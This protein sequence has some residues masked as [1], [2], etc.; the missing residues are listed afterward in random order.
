MALPHPLVTTDD[1]GM[2]HEDA[3]RKYELEES[4]QGSDLFTAPGED[5]QR[6]DARDQAEASGWIPQTEPDAWPTAL[7]RAK[8]HRL[9][10]RDAMSNLELVIGR[11]AGKNEWQREVELAV[12]E[13][14]VAFGDHV[15]EV[16]GNDGLLAQIADE[17]PRLATEIA[18]L[19]TEHDALRRD[20]AQTSTTVKGS[21]D[22][23][24]VE[25]AR[26]DAMALLERLM[27]HRQQGADLVYEAYNVDIA[28]GD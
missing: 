1:R 26:R 23:V 11:P 20:L 3:L 18:R 17:A 27:V 9:T 6:E 24:G 5:L 7:S 8:K 28:T 22:S 10:L 15:D 13:L 2:N 12:E 14:V 21:V 25:T 16:E 19:Q 4:A